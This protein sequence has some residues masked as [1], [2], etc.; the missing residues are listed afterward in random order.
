LWFDSA[1]RASVSPWF[2]F[3]SE[4]VRK[5]E[6]ARDLHGDDGV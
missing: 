2:I 5:V 6:R 1:L 3:V 4:P